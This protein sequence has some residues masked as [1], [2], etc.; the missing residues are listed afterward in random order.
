MDYS[1]K[2]LASMSGLTVRTLQYYDRIGLLVP[3]RISENNYR[4]YTSNEILILQKIL[5][6]KK[7]GFNLKEIKRFLNNSFFDEDLDFH[8]DYLM[9]EK[10][11]IENMINLT[12][13][14]KK[15]GE[16]MKDEDKLKI[17]KTIEN[18]EK[19]YGKEIRKKYGDKVIDNVNYHLSNL[20][21]S[22]FKDSNEINNDIL[23]C[24]FQ[25][26]NS[27]RTDLYSKIFDLHKKWIQIQTGHYDNEYHL[28][29]AYLYVDDERFK[30]YYD[31]KAGDGAASLLSQIIINKLE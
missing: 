27:K 24:L 16:F 15:E 17:F 9:G 26:L 19:N 18:N 20:S 4:I 3:N 30:N 31:S 25:S 29:L 11:K 22:V 1:T 2:Q 8:L 14:I 7:M 23:N 12:K 10:A 21:N 6:Y 13:R 28:N 5:F